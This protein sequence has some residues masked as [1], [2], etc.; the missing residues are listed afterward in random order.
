MQLYELKALG[1]PHVLGTGV[2]VSE[3]ETLLRDALGDAEADF[4]DVV[5]GDVQSV[6]VLT[7]FP[8]KE[9]VDLPGES[10]SARKLAIALEHF[11]RAGARY[12]EQPSEGEY[13][14]GWEILTVP[15]FNNTAVVVKAAWVRVLL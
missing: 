6:R 15:I 13:R 1:E 7:Q 3:L 9:S 2:T 4:M 5:H 10:G 8:L 14:K 11:T 12:S